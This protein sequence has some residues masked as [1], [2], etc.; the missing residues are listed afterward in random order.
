MGRE[1]KMSK[2]VSK[3]ALIGFC[4]PLLDIS[5]HVDEEYLNKY[6]LKPANAILAED[7]HLPIYEEISK[8]PNVEYIA[9][10]AG[11]NTIRAAQWMLGVEGATTFVGC[12]G[13]DQYGAELRKQ[14][15][16][17]GVNV[18]YMETTDKPTGT[19]AV[20]L[21]NK[22]RSMV[23]N[24]SAANLYKH[25]HIKENSHLLDNAQVVYITGFFITVSPDTILAVGK[26]ASE[27]NKILSMNLSAPFI[28]QFFGEKLDECLNYVDLLFG[29]ETEALAFGEK[30][31]FGTNIE[32]IA[33]KAS[34]I[35][36]ANSQ[37]ERTVVFTQGPGKVVVAIGGKVQTHETPV[38]PK[39]EIVDLN[40]AGDC[41]VGGY[42]SQ[43]LQGSDVARCVAAGCYCA[44]VCI[45]RSGITFPSTRPTFQ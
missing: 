28:P 34:L 18:Q 44:G 45:R 17:D 30:K 26:Q 22:D 35:P 27:Q 29:N 43:L 40:G 11:Q 20:L 9:G 38:V 1:K 21:I 16:Q 24:L 31:G 42:L 4:N 13:K 10:G 41:F 3:G 39:E 8:H 6:E 25:D 15:T 14:A 36:K 2:T 7:K 19:C 37:R 23:A 12:I 5:T 33:S 32:E